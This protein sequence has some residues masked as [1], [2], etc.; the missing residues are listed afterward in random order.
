MTP[1]NSLF[2]PDPPIQHLSRPCTYILGEGRAGP[3]TQ[4]QVHS[5]PHPLCS[6][7]RGCPG[8]KAT[9]VSY[10]QMGFSIYRSS[11]LLEGAGD[12][13]DPGFSQRTHSQIRSEKA[14]VLATVRQSYSCLRL[15]RP[16]CS[17][18]TEVC[19]SPSWLTLLPPLPAG[20]SLSEPMQSGTPHI[21][22][23][24]CGAQ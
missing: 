12:V 21:G 20:A 18:I 13:C 24:A 6:I 1:P 15:L 17:E 22:T 2:A 7:P 23:W 16:C 9:Q 4:P 11:N 5:T 8:C 3:K 10:S 19:L 14:F